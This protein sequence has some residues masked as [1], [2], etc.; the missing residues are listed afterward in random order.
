MFDLGIVYKLTRVRPVSINI[1]RIVA[2]TRILGKF[3]KEIL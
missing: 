1:R 2:M 3:L